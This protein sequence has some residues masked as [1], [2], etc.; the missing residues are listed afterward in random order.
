MFGVPVVTL[1]VCFFHSHTRLRVRKTPGFPCALRFM[2]GTK[3][4][5]TRTNTSRERERVFQYLCHSG[6]RGA[7]ARKPYSR[8]WL[9][10]PDRTRL[11]LACPG[12]H[13]SAPRNDERER[14]LQVHL[15]GLADEVDAK[16]VMLLLLHATEAGA[17][18]DAARGHQDALGP[19]RHLFVAFLAGGAD[20][21]LDQSAA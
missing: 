3:D 13:Q 10:V 14:E 16:T 21:L 6:A 17:L 9:W 18:V 20:A 11:R 7:R 5:T 1:L 2:R 8:F 4:G 15:P 19:E 12:R